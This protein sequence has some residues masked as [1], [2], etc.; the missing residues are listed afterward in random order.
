[1]ERIHYNLGG[2]GVF[3]RTKVLGQSLEASDYR[4]LVDGLQSAIMVCNLDTFE[5][6]YANAKSR[7]LLQSIRHL[8]PV[9]PDRIVGT[10]ID[11]FHKNP[12]HQ[13]ALL[14]D[15]SRLPHRARINLGEEVLDL[16]IA[17]IATKDGTRRASLTWSIVTDAVR[18]ER[19]SRR[20][21]QMI[22]KMPINVMTCDPETWKINYV[23][24]TSLETLRSI[25]QH[26]P[27]RAHE[28]LGS[29]IDV[30]HKNPSH[31]HR[32]LA[33]PAN[34]PHNATIR[35]GPETLNLKVSAVM[36]DD[37]TYLG[38]MLTWS[39]VTDTVRMADSV[40]Q[41]VDTISDKSAEMD[42][43]A[44]SLLD[45]SQDAASMSSSVASATE[46]LTSSIREIASQMARASETSNAA[47]DESRQADELVTALA[48][49]AQNIGKITEV[50]QDVASQTN[51]LAL[52]ATIEAARAGEAGKG[53]AVVASEVK[54]LAKKTGAATDEIK[55][56]IDRIQGQTGATVDAI[57]KIGTSVGALNEIS[58]QVA[59]AVEQ[60]SA[61]T[62]EISQTIDGVSTAAHRTGEGAEKVQG[63]A[64]ELADRAST[65][66][67]EIQE[68]LQR[69]MG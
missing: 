24:Q 51:L 27:I 56:L 55:T 29:T 48:E 57:R 26:L 65:L 30:F 20:L 19:E 62:A 22:D 21:L 8:L 38:P 35:V 45:I 25:D 58:A 64:A 14:S 15:P 49:A 52:N 4:S 2:L 16:H 12:A 13:R 68:C 42:S 60:Q 7:E 69:V 59:A 18:A 66:R 6:E 46:E 40:T 17:A 9:D 47:V 36:D 61:A 1:M 5:I 28:L 11:V 33:D 3:L 41:V 34:L 32:L 31:Q 43:S 53:F 10:S 54:N 50:I 63:S 44:R 37:G 67:A 23:N 39:V